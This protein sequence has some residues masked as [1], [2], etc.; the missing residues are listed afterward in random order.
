MRNS[1]PFMPW[2]SLTDR[3]NPFAAWNS[4][5]Y[6]NDP[7][8]PWNTPGADERDYAEYCCENHL[9]YADCPDCPD[10]VRPGRSIPIL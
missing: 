5:L 2:N 3:Y 6:R 10:I 1:N 9:D 7:F 4:P 8:A